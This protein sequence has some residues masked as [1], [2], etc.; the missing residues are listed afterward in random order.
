MKTA[1]FKSDLMRAA[2]FMRCA[3]DGANSRSLLRLVALASTLNVTMPERLRTA[4]ESTDQT[5]H[6]RLIIDYDFTGNA[7]QNENLSV[8][9]PCVIS[10]PADF[11]GHMRE[12]SE[13]LGEAR[14]VINPARFISHVLARYLSEERS[15]ADVI[16]KSDVSF[17]A[18]PS[19][20]FG[21]AIAE[22]CPTPDCVRIIRV[23]EY[24][25]DSQLTDYAHYME[26]HLPQNVEHIAVDGLSI[27]WQDNV[28][29]LTP[30][31][32]E[33][34]N[35]FVSLYYWRTTAQSYRMPNSKEES[36]CRSMLTAFC[37]MP[38]AFA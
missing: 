3:S 9:R 17:L 32:G 6:E 13:N 30:Y 18:V 24:L 38:E 34:V 15:I 31:L 36:F 35:G 5:A 25:L 23:P 22:H 19:F 1:I 26:Q 29:D 11:E 7:R 37:Q 8:T 14:K 33:R 2:G 10:C 28:I 12:V 20:S 21:F 16:D 27:D 4:L